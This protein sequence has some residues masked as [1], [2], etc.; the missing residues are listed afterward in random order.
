M[1]GL[2]IRSWRYNILKG[3]CVAVQYWHTARAHEKRVLHSHAQQMPL[4]KARQEGVRNLRRSTARLTHHGGNRCVGAMRLV[5]VPV[6]TVRLL[7][8]CTYAIGSRL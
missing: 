3:T 7:N 4:Q 8:C 6:L 1:A 2:T 5:R